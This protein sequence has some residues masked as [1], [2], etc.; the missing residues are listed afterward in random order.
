MKN[1]I[2]TELSRWRDAAAR[3]YNKW[4]Q[5]YD[6]CVERTNRDVLSVKTEHATLPEHHWHPL[7]RA[8]VRREAAKQL[9]EIIREVEKDARLEEEAL[10]KR[11]DAGLDIVMEH[12]D[13]RV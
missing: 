8:F 11:S 7:H 9:L 10:K 4:D 5:E 12:T 2:F 1:N 3:V 13:I 6:A